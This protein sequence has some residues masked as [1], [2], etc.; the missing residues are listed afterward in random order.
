[1]SKLRLRAETKADLDIIA[2][3]V[4]DA[5]LR[6]GEINYDVR[7]RSLTLRM[8]RFRHEDPRGDMSGARAQSGL[9]FDGVMHVRTRDIDR[10]DPEAMAVLLNVDF[11]MTDKPAGLIK[12]TFAGGGQLHAEVESL[13]IILADVTDPIETTKLPLHP[14]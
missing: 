10:S 8:T 9:R 1:M 12:L 14:E 5:I 2:A 13:D 7:G 4:Q 3:A 11:E 6:V